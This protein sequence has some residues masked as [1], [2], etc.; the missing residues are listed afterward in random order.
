M[1]SSPEKL[2]AFNGEALL[3]RKLSNVTLSLVKLILCG[4]ILFW[5]PLFTNHACLFFSDCCAMFWCKFFFLF[6]KNNFVY[7]LLFRFTLLQF[8]H[9]S[10]FK[11]VCKRIHFLKNYIMKLFII[12][13]G[14]AI[15]TRSLNFSQNTMQLNILSEESKLWLVYGTDTVDWTYILMEL[16][17]VI[18]DTRWDVIL[19]NMLFFL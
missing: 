5:F 13:Q 16:Y 11:N 14:N 8:T 4:F 15:Q 3:F 19:I 9:K 1:V 10:I 6:I 2:A 18:V 7:I 12:S 17:F